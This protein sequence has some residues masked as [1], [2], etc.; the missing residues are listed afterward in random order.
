MPTRHRLLAVVVAVCWGLN[1]LAIDASLQHFP[2]FFLVALRFALIAVPTVLLVPVPQVP[3]KWLVGYGLG[4][5]TFQFLFLYWGMAVG[6]PAGLSSLVLQAS[7]PFTVVL[8]SLFLRTR[9]TPRAGTGVLVAVIGL[10]VVGWQR[11]D[12]PAA[13]AP[14][15]LVLAGALAWAVGNL[16]T[17]QAKAP[18]PLHLTLWMSVVPP[19]PMLALSLVVE[20]PRRIADSLT[21]WHSPDTV[22]ALVGLAYTIVIGTLL[23]SGIWSWLMARHPAGTVA[24]F[25]MLVPVVGMSAAWVALGE[26]VS[27]G[28]VAGAALVVG[29]VRVATRPPRPAVLT[30]PEPEPEL[31]P[32]DPRPRAARAG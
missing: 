4:F 29:G 19:L 24:P 26:T 16:C 30:Q 9:L 13:F 18:N 28:E 11:L 7:A 32:S 15:V 20:G 25:S 27:R 17:A 23:G 12:G 14:F 8:A 5:G 1:F 6:M 2:P 31:R 3:R 10:A 22:P 21:D